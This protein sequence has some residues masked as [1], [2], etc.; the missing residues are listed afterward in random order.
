MTAG[1]DEPQVSD[2]A[3]SPKMRDPLRGL[4]FEHLAGEGPAKRLGPN[5]VEVVDEVEDLGAQVLLGGKA[6]SADNAA[7][8]DTEPNLNLIQPRG[9]L[10]G[11]NKADAMA[12]VGQELVP[13]S[14]GL[15]H[16]SPALL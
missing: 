12:G 15:Q 4:D 6:A 1:I 13:T 5:L 2:L 11:V 3:Q 14:K 10:G 8:Q 7:D 9:V 16:S